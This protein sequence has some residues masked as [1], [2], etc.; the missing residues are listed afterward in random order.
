MS[1]LYRLYSSKLLQHAARILLRKVA[2][3]RV[4]LSR[5]SLKHCNG[6]RICIGM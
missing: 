5:L 6:I 2:M 4:E 1:L 3:Q